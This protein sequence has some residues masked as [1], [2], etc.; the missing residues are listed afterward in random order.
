MRVG[1]LRTFFILCA[2]ALLAGPIIGL[3]VAMTT[4]ATP[5]RAA[6]E[7]KFDACSWG[8]TGST[9]SSGGSTATILGSPSYLTAEGGQIV[10]NSASKYLTVPHNSSL[11]L[12]TSA[13][14]TFQLWFKLSSLPSSGEA[15]LFVKNSNVNWDGYYVRTNSSGHLLVTTNGTG[16]DKRST[17]TSNPF[18]AGTWY[19]LTVISQI[20]ASSDT[21]KV[22]INNTNVLTTIHGTDTYSETSSLSIGS[23]YGSLPMTGSIGSFYAYDYALSTSDIST[24]YSNL[25]ARQTSGLCA[26]TAPSVSSFTS[27]QATPTNATSFTYALT[28]SE[29]VTDVASGDFTNAGTA[30]GCS[31][32]PGTDTSS[33]TRTVTVTG[34]GEGTVQ[35]RFALNGATNT[36]STTGPAAAA[37]AT[38][39][40]TRDTSGPFLNNGSLGANGRTITLNFDEPV[41][42]TTAPAS[43][44][45]VTAS[46]VNYTP[47]AVS[48]SGSTVELTLPVTLEGGTA[49]TVSYAAPTT[50]SA[51][52][53]AA[54]QD[55]L[56]NDRPSFS[57]RNLTNNS[58]A[59]G[60]SPSATW[61]SP[62]SP[63]SS[64]SL[65][66]SLTFSEA[67][68]GITSS[69]F[70]NLGSA[71]GC[72][73]TP[74]SA[75]TSTS[76]TVAVVCTSDGTLI[77]DLLQN[78]V[79]DGNSNTGPTLVTTA[80]IVTIST[81]PATSSTT[82]TVP[83]S[84]TQ[85]AQ[86]TQ[87]TS[88]TV[89]TRVDSPISPT[90]TLAMASTV[91]FSATTTTVARSSTTTTRVP[92]SSSTTSSS[93][94]STSTTTTTTTTIPQTTTTP[95]EPDPIALVEDFI[96][97]ST[98]EVT[99]LAAE[100]ESARGAAVII[101]GRAVPIDIKTT[102]SSV[103]LSYLN[104]IVEVQCFDTNG[105]ELALNGDSRFVVGK[106]DV[107]RVTVSGFKPGTDVNVAVFSDPTALGTISAD[108][109]GAGRQQWQIPDTLSPG[110]HT[111]VASGDLPE[112]MNT[113][114]GLRV[115]IERKSLVARISSSTTVRFL[116]VLAV[117]VGLFI[118]AGRRRRSAT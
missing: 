90:T 96:R 76:I 53:N 97:T 1:P 62:P 83:S 75:S 92:T 37:T 41:N 81:T 16:I 68:S 44:Y 33:T 69:D 110:K 5:A 28:F 42:S 24:T 15:Y 84:S 107:V 10:L 108:G 32:D 115:Q 106:G 80:S 82:T 46:A 30:T 91:P 73:F 6:V 58:T 63:A 74:S 95:P 50:N 48:V 103:A 61:T 86:T 40:I 100:A 18:V 20:T 109:N 7:I 112:V 65:S 39:T 72:T 87:T 85:T 43:A 45:T 70:R 67:V 25:V 118:P 78:S 66:Y 26:Q 12:T 56:G 17:I 51:T 117:L 101:D 34:C 57:G 99:T 116:L 71:T 59:D 36:S 88:A 89:S 60:T 93:T 13:P 94:T 64:R 77:V 29:A 54:L 114:F 2:V 19:L 3:S 105:N 27:A 79:V 52:S 98:E 102:A 111:L 22:F 23:A 31:F 14:R 47:S 55:S 8:G 9:I 113:V 35:P 49:V 4:P 11:A 21:T 38:T 104:A